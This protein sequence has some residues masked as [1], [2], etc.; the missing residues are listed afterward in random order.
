MKGNNI[1]PDFFESA[2]DTLNQHIVEKLDTRLY[3]A[4]YYCP[5]RVGEGSSPEYAF[6]VSVTNFYGL[7]KDCALCMKER[8]KKI[9]WLRF[10]RSRSIL[11]PSEER[12]IEQC[13]TLIND[14]RSIFCHNTCNDSLKTQLQLESVNEFLQ[15][16]SDIDEELISFPYDLSLSDE[17]WITLNDSLHGRMSEVLKFIA[18]A[19][20]E[21]ERQNCKN[22]VIE[23]WIDYIVEYY[24][25][26]AFKNSFFYESAVAYYQ[27]LSLT[28]EEE[29]PRVD[30]SFGRRRTDRRAGIN[31]YREWEESFYKKFYAEWQ[32]ECSTFLKDMQS[33][34]P[35]LPYDAVK[36]FLER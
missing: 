14:L 35:A 15:S 29:Y 11:S 13:I 7:F 3:F 9:S 8:L 24:K 22:S 21:I 2:V 25:T 20:D 31:Y 17:Q 18:R 36:K 16:E 32:N 30:F 27:W 23:R 5:K 28:D 12:R 26:E 10:L 34:C 19:V 4:A 33:D 1:S 6:W